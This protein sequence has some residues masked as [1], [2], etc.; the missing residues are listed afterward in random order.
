[1][2]LL[3]QYLGGRDQIDK[4]LYAKPAQ[5]WPS[6]FCCVCAPSR[7]SGR[8][9]RVLRWLVVQY[10]ALTP[11]LAIVGL[12]LEQEGNLRAAGFLVVRMLQSLSQLCLL[13]ALSF[14]ISLMRKELQ[15]FAIED[16]FLVVKSIVFFTFWQSVFL[17][18]LA[19]AGGFTAT[20]QLSVA[21][22]FTSL[23]VVH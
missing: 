6:P 15:P 20:A 3:D 22:L 1:M 16:K 18:L 23:R 12:A 11:I 7:P 2:R 8:L 10:I 13:Y 21:G 14:M 4:A 9:F 19:K 5:R 17:A